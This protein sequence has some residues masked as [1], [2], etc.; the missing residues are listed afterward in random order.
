MTHFEVHPHPGSVGAPFSSLV[1]ARHG[2]WPL[3]P[4]RVKQRTER[5]LLRIG[6][7]LLLWQLGHWDLCGKGG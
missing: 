6:G 4:W 5:L 1:H 7:G 3:R 2:D